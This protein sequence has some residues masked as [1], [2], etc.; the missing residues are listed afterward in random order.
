MFKNLTGRVPFEVKDGLQIVVTAKVS[1]YA[2]QSKIQ[3]IVER[4][5][6]CGVGALAL[7]FEQLKAKLESEGLFAPTRKKELVAFPKVVGLVTSPQG[8]ALQDML[9]VLKQRMPSTSVILSPCRVQGQG[10]AQE[11]AEALRRLDATSECDVII[12]GRGGG[13]LEDLW[14]FN[15]EGLA[16]VIASC[17]TPIVSA[18]G[19]ETDFTIADFVADLRAATPTH[20]AATVVPDASEVR[21]LLAHKAARM[22]NATQAKV[23]HHK[24]SIE[25]LARRLGDPRMLLMRH[26][27]RIDELSQKARVLMQRKRMRSLE[28]AQNLRRRL[29]AASPMSKVALLSKR[30][31]TLNQRFWLAHPKSRLVPAKQRLVQCRNRMDALFSTRLQKGRERLSRHVASLC[32]LSPLGVMSRGYAIV[33]QEVETHAKLVSSVSQLSESSAIQIRFSDGSVDAR[34]NR[35]IAM[36]N[37]NGQ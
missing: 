2:P 23:R 3:L 28:Q 33:Y 5:E 15:D 11:I 7:A 16:R 24:L 9:R 17:K 29:E 4:I 37:E 6:P 8:A 34:I 20:A 27:Q 1:V 36:E 13:S 10:S 35:I 21:K 32:A 14:S 19:H 18:V 31:K 22:G 25:K 30:L 26:A 12:I